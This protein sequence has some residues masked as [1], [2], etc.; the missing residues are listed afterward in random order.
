MW[1]RLLRV[2]V[3]ENKCTETL[4]IKLSIAV[5]EESIKQDD[6]DWNC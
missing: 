5:N 1:L 3:N 4:E 6:I 2:I